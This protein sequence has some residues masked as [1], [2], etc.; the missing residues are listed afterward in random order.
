MEQILYL[1]IST[2]VPQPGNHPSPSHFLFFP[3]RP[4]PVGEMSTD[5][6]NTA[7][8]VSWGELQN[9][10]LLSMQVQTFHNSCPQLHTVIT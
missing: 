4:L 6:T 2:S 10:V 8:I 1:R 7:E 3:L 9:H 5:L